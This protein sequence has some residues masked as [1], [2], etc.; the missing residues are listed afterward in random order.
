MEEFYS[1]TALLLGEEGVERLKAASV[2]VFGVGGVG[3]FAVEAL[4]R[5][6]VGRIDVI[7]SDVVSESNLNRQIIATRDTVGKYKTEIIKERILSINQNATVNT[8]NLFFDNQT[9]HLIDFSSY[10][11][12]I[13][14][15]DSVRGKIEIISLSRAAGVR[16]ISCMG[17]GNKL[18]PTRFEIA[19]ISKTSVCPLARAVRYELKK[20]GI[21]GVKVLFSKEPPVKPRAE[22]EGH[23][24]G[25][26][27][28]VPSVAGLIIAGEVIKDIALSK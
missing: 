17:A 7:D 9:S 16:V 28:F 10:D 15:I 8:Y 5:A 19:D 2:A 3:G 23:A 11:Y 21:E 4:A 27:S 18:D 22:D 20:R 1:R 13:D 25:S 26:V 12:V 24:P 6:G 14:A